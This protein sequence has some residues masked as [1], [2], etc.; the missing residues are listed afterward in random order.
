MEPIG[1]ACKTACRWPVEA[2]AQQ[3]MYAK[4]PKANARRRA[5]EGIGGKLREC[6]VSENNRFFH[7][8]PAGCP[9]C[10]SSKRLRDGLSVQ[11]NPAVADRF[12]WLL[13]CQVV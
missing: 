5:T 1:D 13:S 9:V 12:V 11:S 2:K 3:R 10:P 8:L 7:G 4:E 6:F